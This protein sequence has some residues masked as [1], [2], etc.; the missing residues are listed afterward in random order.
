MRAPRPGRI[1]PTPKVEE[2]VTAAFPRTH[3]IDSAGGAPLPHPRWPLQVQADRDRGNH[4]S[5]DNLLRR[6]RGPWQ[7]QGYYIP[8][9]NNWVNWTENAP[10]RPELRMWNMTVN[11]EQGASRSR[12]LFDPRDPANGLH[13]MTPPAVVPTN[14]RYG[15]GNPLMVR[16]RADRLQ[17]SQYSGQSYSSTTQLQRYTGAASYQRTRP[18]RWASGGGAPGRRQ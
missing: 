17:P 2:P 10:V 14:G 18:N 9:A 1:A 7:H 12:A 8:P 3:G 11:P 6:I 15:S 4:T 13:T 16:G 5:N